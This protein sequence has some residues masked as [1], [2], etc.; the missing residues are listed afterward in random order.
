MSSPWVIVGCG[1]QKR[2]EPSPAADLYLGPYVSKAVAWARSVTDDEHLLILSAKY[3]LILGTKVIE[4][5]AASFS[6][7]VGFAKGDR[8]D[9]EQ[10][11]PLSTVRRQI[12]GLGLRGPIICLAG[13]AYHRV[14]VEA[15]M[16]GLRPFNPFCGIAPDD[17]IGYQMQLMTANSGR[18]PR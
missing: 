10:P 7:G 12:A 16:G 18:M 4:P 17:R 11:V 5:Y 15:S 13:K 1:K 6:T 3:G 8:A 9:W 14:L 2:A